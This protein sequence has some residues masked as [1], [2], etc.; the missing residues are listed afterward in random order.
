MKSFLPILIVTL[1]FTSCKSKV[2]DKNATIEILEQF[3]ELQ[4][5]IDS[6]K[7]TLLVL[8]FWSTYCP[9]CIK[10][11]PLFNKLESEFKNKKIRILLISSWMM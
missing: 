1:L 2:T 4:S 3:S 8:N 9:P 11:M 5:I 10:E 7:D 6:E